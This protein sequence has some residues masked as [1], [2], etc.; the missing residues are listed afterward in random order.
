MIILSLSFFGF[1]AAVL[2]IYYLLSRERQ[3]LLLLAASYLFYIAISWRFALVLLFMTLGNYFCGQKLGRQDQAGRKWL[4][5]GIGFNLLVWLFFKC[6][7]FY[8]PQVLAL[9]ARI[10]LDIQAQG[11][12]I[13][14]PIGLSFYTLQAISYLVD[15]DR[16][17][18][19]PRPP[20]VDFALYLAYF[21]K[22]TS[23]PIEQARTFLPQ[24]AKKRFVDNDRLARS[25]FLV[26]LGL[27]RKVVIA[28][29][30]LQN[31]PAQVFTRP[32]EFSGFELIAWL[33]AYAFG[34]YNDFCGYSDIVRGI[35]GFFG[36]SLARNFA[37]PLFARNF[38][39][40]WNR[41]H[42]TLSLW[43]RNYIYFPISRALVRRR[44]GL[45]NPANI[46]L[47]PLIT[48][49][50]SGLWHGPRLSYL[51]WGLAM[52]L[53]LVGENAYASF[54][55]VIKPDRQPWFKQ[56]LATARVILLAAAA[57][58]VFIMAP[59]IAGQ[60][61][62]GI[63]STQRWVLPGSRVFLVMIPS[64]WIDY[65]QDRRQDEFAFLSWPLPVRASL[66]ALAGLFIFL[67]AQARISDPF[68]YQGF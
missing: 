21:P 10:G 60:F 42:I 32:L 40:F 37:I 35:S 18:V 13:L 2:V 48:L 65:V 7:H 30:L 33:F 58:I 20:W 1:S 50:A 64:L 51:L 16:G 61:F 53:Y 29:T 59:P 67:F 52:G 17:Q 6:A 22:L 3:N 68:I 41:W 66:L 38:T 19:T 5:A 44:P 23:G 11:L 34:V 31:I 4:W 43:L 39:E 45:K 56:R 63:F 14:I 49:L 36:I 57:L 9:L 28:D 54:R 27:V 62:Q 24:L 46:V 55:P 12:N 8:V 15:S 47:P 26:V 25:F